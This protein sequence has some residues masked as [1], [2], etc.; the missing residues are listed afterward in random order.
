MY[1][2]SFSRFVR[3][4]ALVLVLT[5]SVLFTNIAKTQTIDNQNNPTKEQSDSSDDSKTLVYVG[6]AAILIAG[7]LYFF[8]ADKKDKD[9]KPENTNIKDSTAVNKI[10]T[11]RKK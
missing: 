10:D 8:L 5:C 2:K 9:K 11:L 3:L 7:A 4:T 1:K 6:V